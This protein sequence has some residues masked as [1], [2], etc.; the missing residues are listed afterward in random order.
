MLINVHDEDG[1]ARDAMTAIKGKGIYV[2]IKVDDV[3]E[4]YEKFV[5]LGLQPATRPRDWPWGNWEFILKD[6]DG[7]KLCFWHR[8]NGA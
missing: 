7:Y 6:P 2:Y 8:I 3:D 5:K 4:S 1:F